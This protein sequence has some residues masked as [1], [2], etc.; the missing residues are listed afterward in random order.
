MELDSVENDL[1]EVLDYL[2]CTWTFHA[3]RFELIKAVVAILDRHDDAETMWHI[4]VDFEKEY[5]DEAG[6]TQAVKR[7]HPTR[8]AI[9]C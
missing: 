5:T 1:V 2:H 6:N 7:T 3:T 9:V 8:Q 4:L